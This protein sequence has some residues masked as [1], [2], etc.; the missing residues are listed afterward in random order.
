MQEKYSELI[1]LRK[2]RLD[3]MDKIEAEKKSIRDKN[4][5][6]FSQNQTLACLA[7]Q[8][9]ELEQKITLTELSK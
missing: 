4:R 6:L 7:N 1:K 5:D 3:L 9:S 2:I 8:L